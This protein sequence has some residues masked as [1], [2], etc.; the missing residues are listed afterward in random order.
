MWALQNRTPY[1]ADRTWI[2]DKTGAHHWVVTVKATF[3][4]G[5]DGSL[6]LA[7]EQKA[8]LLAPE[9]LGKPGESSICYEADLG[10]MKPTTDITLLGSAFSP[11]GRPASQVDVSLRVD[12]ICKVLRV[13]GERIYHQGFTGI[14]TSSPE[15]FVRSAITY[16]RAFGG[17]AA[18][19]AD[20]RKHTLDPRNPIGRGFP[21]GSRS[22]VDRPA[23]CIEYPHLDLVAAGPAGF[24]PLASYWSPRLELWG[25]YDAKWEKTKKPLL[26]DDYD[27]R[28]VLSAPRDQLPARYLRGGELVELINLSVSGITRF[29][30]PKI[31]LTFTTFWGRRYEE[32]RSRLVGVVIEPDASRLLLT[33]QTT[34]LV[35]A[36]TV[37]YLDKTVVGEKAYLA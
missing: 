20:P 12:E 26:P 9:Y 6:R 22:L 14:K 3:D 28:V 5:A 32:H 4:L 35:R 37:D 11:G 30:L 18:A 19:D 33:W 21:A 7:D 10:P 13:Y 16:E 15:P 31:Y 24:G 34:L 27:E 36:D 17:Y 29:R 25:S 1:S 2:R 8:P 23:P